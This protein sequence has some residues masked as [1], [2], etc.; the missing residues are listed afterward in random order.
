MAYK[1]GLYRLVRYVMSAN[2]IAYL[3]NQNLKFLIYVYIKHSFLFY[4]IFNEC[5]FLS[6]VYRVTIIFRKKLIKYVDDTKLNTSI[7]GSRVFARKN[8]LGEYEQGEA[9]PKV[10]SMNCNG[11]DDR[12]KRNKVLTSLKN[13]PEN[14]I[15][16]QETH[17][18]LELES[19]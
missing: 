3:E 8:G 18:T 12:N 17:S 11:L 16:L 7:L 4:F 1:F 5:F 15:L 6:A 14:I 19:E 13:K 2:I 9:G 10:E